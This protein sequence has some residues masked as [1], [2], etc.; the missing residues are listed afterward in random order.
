MPK[1]DMFLCLDGGKLGNATALLGP[2]KCKDG[3]RGWTSKKRVLVMYDEDSL[4]A[5]RSR[6]KGVGSLKQVETLHIVTKGVLDMPTKKRCHYPGSNKSE[7]MAFVK[8]QPW[9]ECWSLTFKD[10]KSLYGKQ[11]VAV[12]G[13]SGDKDDD[14]SDMGS[15]DDD[16]DEADVPPTVDE[17]VPAGKTRDNSNKEPVNYQSVPKEFWEELQHSLCIEPLVTD[18]SPSDG[19]CAKVFLDKRLP[20]VGVCFNDFHVESLYAHLIEYVL[21]SLKDPKS[22]HF[23]ASFRA[24]LSPTDVGEAQPKKKPRRGQSQSPSRSRRTKSQS[25]SPQSQPGRRSRRA[26][27]SRSR[28]RSQASGD[29]R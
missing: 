15:D 7:G 14:K 27:K 19:E 6:V 23:Q 29:S 21:E 4:K 22:P 24:S 28:S 12:G 18:L 2:M 8:L 5:R 3:K 17:D 25:Q 1:G 11:R 10:K 13:P 26:G 20:Y 16:D 9:S